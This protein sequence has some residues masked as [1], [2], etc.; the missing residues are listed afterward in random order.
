MIHLDDHDIDRL[1]AVCSI[2]T[3]IESNSI[4]ILYWCMTFNVGLEIDRKSLHASHGDHNW[5][6]CGL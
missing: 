2:L 3:S 5:P 4:V 1:L 6:L